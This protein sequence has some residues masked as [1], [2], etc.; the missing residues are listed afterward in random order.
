[1]AFFWGFL[2]FFGAKNGVFGQK[3]FFFRG[4]IE[5][6]GKSHFDTFS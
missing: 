1:M 6:N 2:A 4:K 5:K 3:P